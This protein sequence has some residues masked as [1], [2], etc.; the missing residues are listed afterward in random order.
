MKSKFSTSWKASKQPRKQ[1]KYLANAP[2]HLRKKFVNVN[3][4]KELRKKLGKRNI[5]LKKGDKIKIMRGEFKGQTGKVLEVSVKKS[6]VVAEGIQAKK[7][8][9]SKANVKLQPSN[10]QIIELSERVKKVK[11]EQK[12]QAE[13]KP[14]VLN[15]QTKMPNEAKSA[16][17][18]I[19]KKTK[20]ANTD[21]GVK[22]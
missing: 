1:R 16:E 6:F 21:A 18:K 22:E 12:T 14:E 2:L 8:D 11:V 10:L 4:S 17:R 15:P 5:Q 9:G 3:L 20:N 7:R 19:Q 13:K